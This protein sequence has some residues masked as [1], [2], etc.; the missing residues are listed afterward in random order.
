MKVS[1]FAKLIKT[2]T[3]DSFYIFTGE[4]RSRMS[5]AIK[6]LKY[7]K[8]TKVSTIEQLVKLYTTK[9]IFSGNKL[10]VY[11]G[12]D[13]CEQTLSTLQVPSDNMAI[14]IMKNI[15]KRK[16]IFKS[17]K[18]I[19]EFEKATDGVLINLVDEV[20]GEE[21]DE[22]LVLKIINRCN[23]DSGRIEN[24]CLKLK[25]FSTLGITIN[26]DL[27]DNNIAPT[28]EEVAFDL[29]NA[30]ATRKK[31]KA[32]N[33]LEQIYL[34]KENP[35]VIL[36]LLYKQFRNILIIQGYKNETPKEIAMKTSLNVN[37][38]YAIKNNV[39]A[40]NMKELISILKMINEYDVGIKRGQISGDNALDILI[41]KIFNI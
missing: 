14:I 24:E 30:I 13:L 41:L 32:L 23:H 28:I 9:D 18:N 35:V 19:V 21:L 33:L 29:V 27:I 2:N 22:K 6:T 31:E 36:L 40:Y 16:K 4:E 25:E 7:P 15:D 10:L 11:E 5:K 38:I 1:E 26:D 3:L 20:I 12:E 37:M 17:L 34:T 39:G 8:V